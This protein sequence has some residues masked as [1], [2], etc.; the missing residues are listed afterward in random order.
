MSE[1]CD[2]YQISRLT[3][4][5]WVDGIEAEGLKVFEGL[6]FQ[7]CRG[8]RLIAPFLLDEGEVPG[9]NRN[10]LQDHGVHVAATWSGQSDRV[11]SDTLR[12]PLKPGAAEPASR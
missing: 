9:G 5:K 7:A 3:G 6:A 8:H 11:D 1:R 2:R 12:A 4:Y 10:T